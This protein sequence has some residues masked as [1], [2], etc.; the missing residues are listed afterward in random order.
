MSLR[1]KVLQLLEASRPLGRFVFWFRDG[2][3]RWERVVSDGHDPDP[4]LPR[5]ATR[6]EIQQHQRLHPEDVLIVDREHEP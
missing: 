4:D 1:A 6:A 3:D 2:P 5:Y